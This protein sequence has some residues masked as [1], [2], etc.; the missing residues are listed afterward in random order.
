MDCDIAVRLY[1][2]HDFL[3]YKNEKD[4]LSKTACPFCH[5][6]GTSASFVSS[7]SRLLEPVCLVLKKASSL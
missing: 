4:M 7:V 5:S 2:K 3:L 1:K 6:E